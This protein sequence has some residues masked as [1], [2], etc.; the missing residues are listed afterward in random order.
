MMLNKVN[1]RSFVSKMT[2]SDKDLKNKRVFRD[3]YQELKYIELVK[4][5]TVDFDS[6]KV[7][8]FF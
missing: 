7:T 6:A 1:L 4:E 2:K 3:E 5:S 8:I